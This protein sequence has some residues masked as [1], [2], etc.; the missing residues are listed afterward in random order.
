MIV[1]LFTNCPLRILS[2]NIN[3][4]RH[5]TNICTSF[6]FT[7][8]AY[9][10]RENMRFTFTGPVNLNAGTNKIALLSLA[11]GLPVS[12]LQIASF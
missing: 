4:R 3:E 1:I 11:V 7:G 6:Y 2:D 8:S 5:N 9:G 10:S 12:S